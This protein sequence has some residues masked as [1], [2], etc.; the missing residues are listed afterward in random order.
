MSDPARARLRWRCRRGMK[1]LDI[2]LVRWIERRLGGRRTRSAASHSN[3][4][5]SSPTRTSPTGWSA[6]RARR[7]PRMPRS[8][9]TSFAVA[10]EPP[11][12]AAPCGARA[13][14]APGRGR[15]SLD[16]A[17]PAVAGSAADVARSR[18]SRF[19]T[20]RGAGTSP[21]PGVASG[22]T[23]RA[24]VSRM[25]EGGAW[26][27]AELG[28]GSRAYAGLAFLD[29]RA[30]G[31]RHAWLLPRRHGPGRPIPKPQGPDPPDL[32]E[33]AGCFTKGGA[34]ARPITTLRTNQGSAG[35]IGRARGG[36]SASRRAYAG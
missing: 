30:G 35:H 22:A 15:E 29:I 21:P 5:S 24:G 36:R 34:F 25:R 1:E 7:T 32:L 3:G 12:D 28:P 23:A 8:S 6:A 17:C 20:R 26:L 31:R 10:I 9:M 13:R 27:A 19:D 4:C 33:F 16:R 14:R 2:L 11:A 18:R